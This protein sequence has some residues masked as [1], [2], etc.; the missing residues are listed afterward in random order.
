MSIRVTEEELQAL[1]DMGFDYSEFERAIINA[2][3]QVA[4]HYVS[5]RSAVGRA[6]MV[7]RESRREVPSD[8]GF[9]LK[10][11]SLG[12]VL[13]RTTY[14]VSGLSVWKQLPRDMKAYN[15]VEEHNALV[16]GA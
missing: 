2:T 3:G 13:R 16:E 9:P 10:I 8:K 7:I 6:L 15:T 11:E 1:I 5:P 12:A 4:A 14:P